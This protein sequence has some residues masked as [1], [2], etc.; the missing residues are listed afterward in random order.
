M[1]EFEKDFDDEVYEDEFYEDNIEEEL[2]DEDEKEIFEED[3]E[4]FEEAEKKLEVSLACEDCDYR[5]ED[6]VLKPKDLDL[7]DIEIVCPMCGSINV[8][9]I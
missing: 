8:T 1:N 2:V 5:W 3:D 7:D 6:V 4:L 9:Q